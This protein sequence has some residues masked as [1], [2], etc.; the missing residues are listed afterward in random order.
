MPY[1][2]SAPAAQ[3]IDWILPSPIEARRQEFMEDV[4]FV[5]RETAKRIDDV[6]PEKLS[7]NEAF[8]SALM[9]A[10]RIAMSSHNKDKR[11]YLRK[12]LLNIATGEMIDETKQRIFLNAVEAFTPAHVRVVHLMW[13]PQV[14]WGT[15]SMAQRQWIHAVEIAVPGLKGEE[16]LV[17]AIFTDVTNRGFSNLGRPDQP[18]PAMGVTNL[19][20]EFCRFILEVP[21]AKE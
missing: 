13:K 11:E 19:G 7:K 8:V 4:A 21:P 12:A 9:Q 20:A 6:T 15:Q 16:H 3:L 10:S 17:R 1:W 14:S 5:V 2:W 18:F